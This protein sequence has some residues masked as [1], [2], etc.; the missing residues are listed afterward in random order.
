MKT[1]KSHKNHFFTI[2]SRINNKQILRQKK[3]SKFSHQFVENHS[4]IT[5]EKK[6]T[7]II[8]FSARK[9]TGSAYFVVELKYPCSTKLLK[10]SFF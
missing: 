7:H 5:P 2:V 3:P 8:V 4:S 1:P 9:F 6:T 10:V